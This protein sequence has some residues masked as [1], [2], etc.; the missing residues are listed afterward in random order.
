MRKIMLGAVLYPLV[1]IQNLQIQ[2]KTIQNSNLRNCKY[3]WGK[4]DL[5]THDTQLKVDFQ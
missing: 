2:I 1:T 3:H 4:N 5:Q